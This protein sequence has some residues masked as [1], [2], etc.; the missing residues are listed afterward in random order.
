MG[1]ERPGTISVYSIEDDSNE[2]RF[3]SVNFAGVL[4]EG[5]T[6]GEMYIRRSSGDL[7]P[8]DVRLVHGVHQVYSFVRT[9]TLRDRSV[10]LETRAVSNLVKRVTIQIKE[11]L[12]AGEGKMKALNPLEHK[13]QRLQHRE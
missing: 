3:E 7:D 9:T 10:L 5:R 8:E 1:N 6:W 2:P 12:H 11:Y 13:S 4:Q